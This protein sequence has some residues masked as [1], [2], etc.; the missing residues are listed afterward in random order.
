MTSVDFESKSNSHKKSSSECPEG[1]F[2]AIKNNTKEGET[3][4][5]FQISIFSFLDSENQRSFQN[6]CDYGEFFITFGDSMIVNV[7]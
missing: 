5:N 4:V 7:Q 6:H 2:F 1:I 3:T